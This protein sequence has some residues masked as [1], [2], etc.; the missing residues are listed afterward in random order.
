M[1]RAVRPVARRRGRRATAPAFTLITGA[2]RRGPVRG[3]ALARGPR[4]LRG[5]QPAAGAARRRWPSSRRDPGGPA[6]V[7]IVVDARGGV[8]F[9][10]LSKALEELDRTAR[11][12]PDRV[13]GGGR[14]RPGQPVRGHAPPPSARAG[15]PGRRGHPQGA[16]DDGEP[17]RRRRPH[18]RHLRPHAARAPRPD[19]RG[20]RRVA[21]RA[22]A[23]G[24]ARSRSASSTGRRA[25]PTSCSTSGSCP[26]RTGSRSS[27]RCP[28]PIE[29]CATYVEGQPQ[30]G[31]FVERL[32]ALM[33]VIVPGLHRR[34]E[35]LPDDR[36]R[37]HRRA[38]SL[39]RGGRGAG[40]VLQGARAGGRRG[41]PRPRPRATSA[42]R[43][44]PA[45]RTSRSDAWPA[46]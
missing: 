34:G 8:F 41:A 39:G 31:E 4:V 38:P 12:V 11:G 14:R 15:R 23:Q 19:P 6:R 33:D 36:G 3:R 21:A 35:G 44:V 7:A 29:R 1:P 20:V 32:E 46:G 10:E 16:P 13:P 18:H 26:T 24:L 43:P 25:T 9:G 17:A 45:R 22:R 42:E 37:L 2:V 30:Y 27:G 28:A 5:R 40:P